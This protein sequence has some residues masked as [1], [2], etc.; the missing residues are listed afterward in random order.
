[1]DGRRLRESAKLG[2]RS[3][4][5]RHNLDL[6][7]NP[8]PRRVATCL[9]WLL[10]DTVLDVGANIGQYASSLRNCGF[11]GRVISCEPLSGAF[12]DLARR[13]ARDQ[14]WEAVHTAVGAESGVTTIHV[15][16]N[17][18]SSSL[19]PMT[20]R[21]L[22]ADPKSRTTSA[23]Q[24]PVTTV[25]ALTDDYLVQ[26]ERCLLKIDTQGFESHVLDGAGD[27][28]SYFAAIQLELS[29]AALYE[30]QTLYPD[31]VERLEGTGYVLFG[32]EPGIGDPKTGQ[33]LQCDGLF[34]RR[35]RV[36]SA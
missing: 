33:L 27:A 9:E 17:S 6:G 22:S 30:G 4:L 28:L 34:V 31:L 5:Y 29:F 8:F 21:H 23:E 12:A 13:S 15:S 7:L 14:R 25:A 26:A 1:M 10:A 24:V 18:Y 19:L 2:I 3:V 16:A 35:D 11:Q 36:D 20:Q 32:F